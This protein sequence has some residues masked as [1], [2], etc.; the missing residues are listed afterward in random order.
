MDYK[1]RIVSDHNVMLGK[2]IVKGTRITVELLL[3]KLSEG[4]SVKDLLLMYE[5]IK[6]EDVYA[7]LTYAS[8]V[9]G[10][11]EILVSKK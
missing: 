1:D 10:N 7:A 9:I 8:D 2:P 5:N 6:E 3:R 4:V 11:E